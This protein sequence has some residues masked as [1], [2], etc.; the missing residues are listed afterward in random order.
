MSSEAL[1]AWWHWAQ[2]IIPAPE[3]ESGLRELKQFLSAFTQLSPLDIT[4]RRF[5]P[6]IPLKLPLAE[7]QERWQRRWQERV[8][9][10]YLIGTV[11][12]HDLELVVTPSVLI[13]RPETEELLEVVAVTVPPWQQQGH[14]LDLGTGSGAIAIGLARLFAAALVHAVD[15][16]PEAL[17]V[18][19]VNIQKYALGDRVRCYVGSWFAPL[20]HLQG[21]VQGIVSNPPYIPTRLVATL[22]PEVQ[23]HEPPL[24]LDG[25]ADGL[26]AI[27]QIVETA[28]EYLQPQGWLFIEL[29]ATQGEAVAALAMAS[30][31]YE[32]VEILRDL[33]GHDRFLLAQA[34]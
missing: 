7:L 13:P 3:R 17:E 22:Q 20:T 27:R 18:A 24:A 28:P 26:Q 25:G 21:Q 33:S 6:E 16:S 15:C 29:M 32:R 1:Q 11:H 10:Q 2:A 34:V 19:Q 14:W 31:A 12:W 23:Y 30:Q 9:L 4:L 5:P 8:P